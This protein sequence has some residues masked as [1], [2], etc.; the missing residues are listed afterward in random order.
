MSSNSKEAVTKTVEVEGILP[1]PTRRERDTT[2]NGVIA[3]TAKSYPPR[4]AHSPWLCP[5]LARRMA[6]VGNRL[7]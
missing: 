1:A 3:N 7:P 4:Q 5:Q 2:P 6:I